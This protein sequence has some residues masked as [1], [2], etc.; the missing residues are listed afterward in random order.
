VGEFADI[1]VRETCL[2]RR[3]QDLTLEVAG[4]ATSP[5]A[6]VVHIDAVGNA[7]EPAL[8]DEFIEFVKQLVLAIVVAVGI[9]G[10]IG[11]VRKFVGGGELVW[12]LEARHDGLIPDR[13]GAA[14]RKFCGAK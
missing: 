12:Q 3:R 6:L 2:G 14:T 13:F 1:S 7:N 9:V 11:G 5:A 4:P 10:T 8:S